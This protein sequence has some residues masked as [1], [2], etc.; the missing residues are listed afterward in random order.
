MSWFG[1]IYQNPNK[2]FQGVFQAPVDPEPYL[3]MYPEI[4]VTPEAQL[5]G[6]VGRI[7]DGD[8]VR[9]DAEA[10]T[11][12]V[13]V[14]GDA[15]AARSAQAPCAEAALPGFGRE[16][17]ATFRQLAGTAERGASPLQ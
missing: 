8:T 4:Q 7:R 14:A 5:G 10:G 9:L 16:L 13:L 1:G 6:A 3:E 12:E 11:L 2:G 15:L 17:F